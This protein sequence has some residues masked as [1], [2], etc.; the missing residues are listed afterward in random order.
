MNKIFTLLAFIGIVSIASAQTS[1][2]ILDKLSAKA[3]TYKTM[4][5]DFTSTLV[6]PKAKLNQQ[7]TG[8]VKIKG[9]KY[10]I[11]LSDYVVISDGVTV[12]SYSKKDNECTIDNLEDVKD[13]SFDPSDMFTLWEKDFRHEMKNAAIT[14]DAIASYQI[15]LY[16]SDPKDKPYH[17]IMMYVDKA[18]M[19]V[20]KIVVKQREG[21]EITYKVK[22]FKT[23][24]ELPDTDFQFNK[25]KYPGCEMTDNRI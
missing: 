21:G 23:N 10:N 17:T 22:N 7:Q 19:E 20:H 13:G 15:A 5:A 6:D 18:K 1:K 24:M 3:K 11:N 16:P 8:S 4:S 12:W 14:E 25:T 2:D 9:Q